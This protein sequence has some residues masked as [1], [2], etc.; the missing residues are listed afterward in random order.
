MD[1]AI[2]KSKL[3]P[4]HVLVVLTCIMVTVG[5]SALTFST[6]GSFQPVVAKYF[7]VS[8]TAFGSYVTVIYLTEMV[9]APFVGKILDK[10]D[11]RIL[12]T[13]AGCLAAAAFLLQSFFTQIF[14][15]YLASVLLGASAVLFIWLVMPY[16]INNW[17]HKNAGLLIGICSAFTGIGGAIWNAV[18]T[19]LN[20]GGM[21]YQHIYLIWA[22]IAL[23]TS[24]PFTIFCVRN[25]PSQ[26]GLQPYGIEM[27]A[28]KTAAP[29]KLKG[30]SAKVVMRKPVF[31]AMF[32]FGGFINCLTIVANQF[33]TYVKSMNPATTSFNIVL[34]AGIMITVASVGQAIA[35]ILMGAVADKSPKGALTFACIAGVIG[36]LFC[37]LGAGSDIMLYVGAFIFGFFFASAMVV[38]PMV[39]KQVFGMR[40]Y[41]T[42]YSR[43]QIC[44]NLMGALGPI[45]W[46]FLG[47]TFGYAWVFVI[48]IIMLV[49]VFLLGMY[50]FAASKNLPMEEE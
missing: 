15:F 10:V 24:V 31:W 9:L 35:K 45:L 16:L 3:S 25:K 47:S 19:A 38:L 6:W 14:E 48:A 32:F 20:L 4:R 34:V 30:V 41:S 26:C 29:I 11:I 27:V 13:I 44:V 46:A 7:G 37:W 43:V 1:G 33:P 22:V 39:A 21:P 49:I 23:V 17:F 5:C 12:M 40:E 50:S 36:I 28:D 8:T 2:Q 18:F 42:I